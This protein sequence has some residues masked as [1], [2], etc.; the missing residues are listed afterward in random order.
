MADMGTPE[1]VGIIMDGNGRWA[2][3]RL[4]PRLAGHRAGMKRML[5]LLEH[6]YGCGVKC[7][8][9]FALSAENLS[10]PKDELDGLFALFREYFSTQT[11]RLS[12]KGIR[13]RVIGDRGLIPAD[14]VSLIKEG[15]EKTAKG[16]RATLAIAIGYGGRQDIVAACNK[17]VRAGRE[18]T[19][20]SFA[21]TLSTG[22]MP[23]L[24]L[25]IRTGDEKRLSN[26]LLFEAA[27][28]ELIFS[29][30]MFPDYTDGDFDEALKEY[31]ARER[32]FGALHPA[33]RT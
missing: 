17:A 32:R 33:D 21:E 27:Y 4:L 7:V 10:R 12:E 26:F 29:T 5:A 30:K 20:E 19:L 8:T 1:H 31:A 14:I 2:K 15:E 18:V 3:R 25:L 24:D 6:I 9:V 28:A 13:L 16:E 23:A 11:E 22:G